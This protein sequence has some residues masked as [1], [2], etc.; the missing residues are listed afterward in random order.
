MRCPHRRLRALQGGEPIAH[1]AT[2]QRERV[3][4]QHA[5]VVSR[6]AH[7]GIAPNVVL[8]SLGQ[9]LPPPLHLLVQPLFC[10]NHR[11]FH[12]GPQALGGRVPAEREPERFEAFGEGRERLGGCFEL[13]P[14][15]LVE[16][17][18][19]LLLERRQQQQQHRLRRH[20]HHQRIAQ[21]GARDALGRP[22]VRH[23]HT[24]ER[25]DQHPEH[26]GV[27]EEA[28]HRAGGA[29]EREQQRE[30][31]EDDKRCQEAQRCLERAVEQQVPDQQAGQR[32]ELQP[33]V[34]ALGI[35]PGVR[36]PQQDVGEVVD[37]REDG[38]QGPPEE[39][40]GEADDDVDGGEDGLGDEHDEGAHAAVQPVCPQHVEWPRHCLPDQPCV[41]GV[42]EIAA[43][44]RDE[45][46][47]GPQPRCHCFHLD[48][49]VSDELA[50]GRVDLGGR[51][52]GGGPEERLEGERPAPQAHDEEV[53]PFLEHCRR[54][55]VCDSGAPTRVAGGDGVG[56]VLAGEVG[57]G[58]AR[59]ILVDD[60]V[61][62]S[63]D[64]PRELVL[65]CRAHLCAQHLA[66]LP[67][68][69]ALRVHR[70]AL[71]QEG[72]RLA[73]GGGRGEQEAEGSRRLQPPLLCY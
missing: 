6:H 43:R 18:Q 16:A 35:A 66:Q 63:D 17:L 26:K 53:E 23:R 61:L 5:H 9:P 65:V 39:A 29:R 64:A 54:R 45:P 70:V 4:E 11:F 1:E 19:L 67:L 71:Q 32:H 25:S 49:G 27:G 50:R 44:A 30:Q 13:L 72:G 33:R 37:E 20:A 52:E 36:V 10:R 56:S 42:F 2:Q 14:R 48:G 58:R 73:C 8:P 68:P 55:L 21:P 22:A 7:D 3:R 69:P 40:E 34:V 24:P 12:L 60:P 41:G 51:V 15:L 59:L 47:Q 57:A 62:G 28:K 38:R 31:G 46:P